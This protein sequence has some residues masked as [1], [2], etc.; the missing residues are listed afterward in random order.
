MQFL[1]FSDSH[2]WQVG[3]RRVLA[4]HPACKNVL[5]LGDG[6]ED[7]ESLIPKYPNIHFRLVRGN[8]DPFSFDMQ[9]PLEDSFS[10]YGVKVL[11]LH[12]HHYGVKGGLSA[13][14]AHARA[15]GAKVLLYGHTHMPYSHYDSES[16]L[17]TF[18]PGSIGSPRMGRPPSFGLLDILPDGSLSLSHGTL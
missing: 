3:L 12:G 15:H 14:E 6:I 16:G 8:C 5:F 1:I 17:Y 11:M 2:R 4:E 18:N 13:A 10:L 7:F 9:A